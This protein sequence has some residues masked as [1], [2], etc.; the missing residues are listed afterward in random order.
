MPNGRNRS[1]A[2]AN[3]AGEMRRENATVVGPNTIRSL[4]R[5]DKPLSGPRK[6]LEA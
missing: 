4:S 1:S 2:A 5:T 3:T 6:V